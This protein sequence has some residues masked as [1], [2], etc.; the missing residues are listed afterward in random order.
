MTNEQTRNLEL[1]MIFFDRSV[2]KV[3][4]EFAD[5]VYRKIEGKVV[6]SEGKG[7]KLSVFTESGERNYKIVQAEPYSEQEPTLVWKGKRSHQIR[8][9]GAGETIT[10]AS[11][12]GK[13]TFVKTRGADN[14]LIRKLKD[15]ET[16]QVIENPTQVTNVLGL[17]HGD[18]GRLEFVGQD[19]FVFKRL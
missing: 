4:S 3:V 14:I 10:Y 19:S 11:R 17:S 2:D 13:L 6:I 16:G 9:L 15:L 1:T 7:K 5:E 8:S 12:S 18:E